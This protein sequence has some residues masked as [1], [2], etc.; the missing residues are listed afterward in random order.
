MVRLDRSLDWSDDPSDDLDDEADLALMYQAVLREAASTAALNRWLDARTL[1]RLWPTLWLP[2]ALRSAWRPASQISSRPGRWRGSGPHPPSSGQ[3]GLQA[4]ARFGL[5]LAGGC[6]VQ[7]HGRIH[8][9]SED[10]DLFTGWDHRADFA[11]AVTVVSAYEGSSYQVEV[12]EVFAMLERY[13]DRRL[14]A[15]GARPEH[16]QA[17][18]ARFADWRAALLRP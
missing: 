4:A 9:P 13:P 2:P 10:V 11:D 12:A 15:Y 1:R 17:L 5:A 18:R 7:E 3:V 8:R 6:A 16:I 14:A